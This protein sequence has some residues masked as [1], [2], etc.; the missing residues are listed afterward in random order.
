MTGMVGKI[1]SGCTW[2]ALGWLLM[3]RALTT[4][5]TEPFP[6]QSTTSEL[7]PGTSWTDTAWR[8]SFPVGSSP[9]RCWGS[10]GVGMKSDMVEFVRHALLLRACEVLDQKCST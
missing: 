6:V 4:C 2:Q 1:A 5:S 9:A 10:P 3:T 7:S 8:F